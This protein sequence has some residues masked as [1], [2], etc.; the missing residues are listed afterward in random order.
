VPAETTAIFIAN[1]GML[2]NYATGLVGSRIQAE[3]L[4]QE[5]WLKFNEAASRQLLAEPLHYLFRIIRNLAVDGQRRQDFESRLFKQTSAVDVARTVDEQPTAEDIAV[6]RDDLRLLGEVLLELP[7]RTR[8][9]FE[10]HCFEGAKLREIAAVLEISTSAAH[11]LVVDG[12]EHC[13]RRL[14]WD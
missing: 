3:D 12:I 2:V 13:K 1:R 11:L 7:E 6:H 9:A 10:M 14:G 5:A 4:V 8:L